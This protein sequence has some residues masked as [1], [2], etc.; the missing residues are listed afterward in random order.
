MKVIVSVDPTL[1]FIKA[2]SSCGIIIPQPTNSPENVFSSWPIF[3]TKL[4]DVAQVVTGKS[5]GTLFTLLGNPFN[6]F[7]AKLECCD[8]IMIIVIIIVIIVVVVIIIIVVIIVVV[9]ETVE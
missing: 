9:I 5:L 1:I 3:I 6:S 4:T 8:L 2:F 7:S